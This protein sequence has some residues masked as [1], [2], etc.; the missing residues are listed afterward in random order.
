MKNLLL[1]KEIDRLTD[2]SQ[3]MKQDLTDTRMR[4][5]DNVSLNK[6]IEEQLGLFVVL[7]A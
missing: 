2:M 4:L 6:R 1:S 3:L 7:F 5:T